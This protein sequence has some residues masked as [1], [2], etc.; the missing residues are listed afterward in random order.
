MTLF[1]ALAFIPFDSTTRT[2][3]ALIALSGAVGGAAVYAAC[4]AWFRI[5]ELGESARRFRALVGGGRPRR[6][7]LD[8]PDK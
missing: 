8:Q 7:R 6:S 1:L 2:D 5:P 4:A 3:E